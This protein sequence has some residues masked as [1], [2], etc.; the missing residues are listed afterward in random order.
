MNFRFGQK[1]FP[2]SVAAASNRSKNSWRHRRL[3]PAPTLPSPSSGRVGWGRQGARLS[4][5]PGQ[6]QVGC[7]EFC[8]CYGS[9]LQPTGTVVGI[10]VRRTKLAPKTKNSSP[11]SLPA[12]IPLDINLQNSSHHPELLLQAGRRRRILE[13]QPL[14]GEDVVV[15]LLG[16]Q[17]CLVEAAQDELELARISVDVADREDAR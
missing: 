10:D 13:H 3:V 1:R 11:N 14:A 4:G 17:G 5:R 2:C 8:P 7:H 15:G 16:H 6:D 12:A 9:E